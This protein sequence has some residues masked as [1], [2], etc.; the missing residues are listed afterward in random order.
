[1]GDDEL[2]NLIERKL[3]NAINGDGSPESDARQKVMDYYLGERYGNEREGHSSVVT[4]E[5][6]EAVEWAIPSIMRVF[7]GER[8]ASFIPEGHEDE[9]AAEQETDVVNHLLFEM[10]NGYLALQSLVK[11]CLMYPTGYSKICVEQVE[12]VKT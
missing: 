1:M 11:D 12:K 8:V 6:F 2:V 10:E 3:E 5:V 7:S 4:R 9:Q